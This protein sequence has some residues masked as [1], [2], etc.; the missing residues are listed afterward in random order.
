MSF[1]KVQ[2][3]GKISL[4]NFVTENV[5]LEMSIEL[6]ECFENVTCSTHPGGHYVAASGQQKTVYLDFVKK[7]E[8]QS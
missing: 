8:P 2:I 3:I 7:F 6:S 5:I 1:P 4:P